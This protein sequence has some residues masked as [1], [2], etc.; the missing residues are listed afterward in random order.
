MILLGLSKSDP[1][2]HTEEL[3]DKI[4]ELIIQKDQEEAFFPGGAGGDAANVISVLASLVQLKYKNDDLIAV[5][6]HQL[7]S[8]PDSFGE[9]SHDQTALFIKQLSLLLSDDHAM[10]I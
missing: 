10:K 4:A 2:E 8:Y 6:L 7:V 3:L 9:L 5:F 1:T